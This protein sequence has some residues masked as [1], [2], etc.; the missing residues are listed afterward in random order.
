MD[1]SKITGFDW[2]KGNFDK[3]WLSH[4]VKNSEAEEVF[5]NKPLKISTNFVIADEKE[6]R[7]QALGVTYENRLLS[8]IFTV[9]KNKIRIISARDMAKKER[10]FFY[11]E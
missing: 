10:R 6:T 8:V 2:N 11:E 4:K 1:L 9:R 3:N 7:Y 5:F